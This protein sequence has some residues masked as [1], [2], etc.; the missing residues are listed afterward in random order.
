MRLLS[1]ALSLDSEPTLADVK[2]ALADIQTVKQD[3]FIILAQNKMNYVQ[4]LYTNEGYF[5]KYQSGSTEERFRSKD[6]LNQDTLVKAFELYF[7]GDVSWKNGIEFEKMNL[8]KP[9]VFRLGYYAG[10]FVV[11]IRKFFKHKM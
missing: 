4:A 11:K 5:L 3:P 6:A 9:F 1:P 2:K 8:S 7:Q 10:N